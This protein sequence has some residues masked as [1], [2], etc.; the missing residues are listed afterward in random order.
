MGTEK[1][2]RRTGLIAI[3]ALVVTLVLGMTIV[4]AW[5]YFTANATAAGEMEITVKPSTHITEEY[6]DGAK[7][8]FIHNDEDS[9]EDVVVRA[10]VFCPRPLTCNISG[11]NWMGPAA[12]GWYLYDE[13]VH[14]GKSA[15]ELMV[16]IS[17]LEEMFPSGSNPQE[18]DYETNFNVVVVYEAL[19]ASQATV[20]GD[21]VIEFPAGWVE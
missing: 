7:H 8:V 2:M 1:E 3:V 17:G 5:A 18:S 21:Y 10:K 19:P 16:Q 9:S 20:D 12:E 11:T 15:E 14:P 13:V 4:P 6:G